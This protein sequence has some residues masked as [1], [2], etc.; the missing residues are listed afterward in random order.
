MKMPARHLPHIHT[1]RHQANPRRGNQNFCVLDCGEGAKLH[2][3][4]LETGGQGVK[5]Y[6]QHTQGIIIAWGVLLYIVL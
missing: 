3:G 5:W 1:P 2:A 4:V 6:A